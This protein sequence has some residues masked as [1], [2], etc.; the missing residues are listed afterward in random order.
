MFW[1]QSTTVYKNNKH[2]FPTLHVMVISEE[3]DVVK[4][5]VPFLVGL[6]VL[7]K[8]KMVVNKVPDIL[9]CHNVSYKIPLTRKHGHIY[10]EWQKV[11]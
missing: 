6:D 4:S 7:N 1:Q 11:H 2:R 3:S 10:L 8:Y 9:E 5:D